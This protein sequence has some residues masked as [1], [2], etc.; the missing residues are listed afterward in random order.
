MLHKPEFDLKIVLGHKFLI[1]LGVFLIA[2]TLVKRNTLH[3]PLMRTLHQKGI[4]M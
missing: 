2:V 4:L 1:N 3:L